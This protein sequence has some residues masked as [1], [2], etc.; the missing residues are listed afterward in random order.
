MKTRKMKIAGIIIIACLFVLDLVSKMIVLVAAGGAPLWGNYTELFPRFMHLASLGGHFNII[1]VWN[2]GVSFSIFAG[3]GEFA[4]WG[5]V[6]LSLVIIGFIC[7][8]MKD[9]DETTDIVGFSMIVGGALGNV[10]DRVRYG[11]VID[12]IDFHVGGFHWPAFNFADASIC[13][14]VAV[15]IWR[16]VFR[17]K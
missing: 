6:A 3:L 5:L 17:S 4:R 2:T 1:L 11:A 16:Q 15:L 14:G 12:F 7:K 10:L 9:S 13:L 8:M